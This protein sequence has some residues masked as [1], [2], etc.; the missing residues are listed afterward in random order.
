MATNSGNGYRKGAIKDRYQYE[1]PKTGLYT[2]VDA[3]TG[4]I[5]DVKTSGGKF[6]GVPEYTDDRLK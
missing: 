6:K 5:M 4:K 1:N 2:K 3:D